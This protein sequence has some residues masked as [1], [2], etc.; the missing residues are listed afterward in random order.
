MD[1]VNLSAPPLPLPRTVHNVL[2]ICPFGCFQDSKYETDFC[3]SKI[4]NSV[5]VVYYKSQK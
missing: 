4:D 2:L 5:F 1:D 3:T